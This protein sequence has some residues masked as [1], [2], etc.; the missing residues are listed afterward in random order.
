MRQKRIDNRLYVFDNVPYTL[1]SDLDVEVVYVQEELF[2]EYAALNPV[3]PL[4]KYNYNVFTVTKQEWYDYINAP[5]E[6][7]PQPNN[8]SPSAALPQEG[9]EYKLT[10]FDDDVAGIGIALSPDAATPTITA[11]LAEI[12]S[13]FESLGASDDSEPDDAEGIYDMS[14]TISGT[15]VQDDTVTVTK[16]GYGQ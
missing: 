12:Q 9:S 16:Q 1:T 2:N 5:D 8:F 6:I 13:F 11:D 3:L 4:K 10:M 7:V 14:L 15:L